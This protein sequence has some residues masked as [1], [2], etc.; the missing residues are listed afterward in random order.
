LGDKIR[1]FHNGKDFTYKVYKNYII[2]DTDWNV[3][4][5]K[6][7]EE[8]TLITCTDDSKERYIL[9]CKEVK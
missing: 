1:Y 6:N 2:L 5:E 4:D 3:L 8:I 9:K 7:K